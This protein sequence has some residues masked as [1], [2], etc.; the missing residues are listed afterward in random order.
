MTETDD[1]PENARSAGWIEAHH[2]RNS[3]TESPQRASMPS[4]QPPTPEEWEGQKSN[5]ARLYI[6]QEMPLRDVMA[7]ME[8]SYGFRAS[9]R[10][11][12][13]RLRA[14]GFYKNISSEVM[15]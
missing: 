12:K 7:L 8:R 2:D 15:E 4:R 13:S 11:Y 3:S 10:M 9:A 6:D 1:D 5:I 14:W